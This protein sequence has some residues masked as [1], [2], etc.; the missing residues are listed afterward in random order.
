MHTQELADN[1][2]AEGEQVKGSWILQKILAILPMKF[3]HFRSA[4]DNVSAV[5]N[6]LTNLFDRFRLEE[7]RLADS[8]PVKS[9]PQNALFA[10]QVNKSAHKNSKSFEIRSFQTISRLI[11]LLKPHKWIQV[12]QLFQ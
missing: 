8:E 4:W 3:Q 10:K 5:D 12:G 9:L 7:D 2:S 11:D 6:N 1:L